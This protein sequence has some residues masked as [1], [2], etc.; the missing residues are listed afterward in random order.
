MIY[1]EGSPDWK[2][3]LELVEQ[4]RSLAVSM[5]VRARTEDLRIFLLRFA[6]R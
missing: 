1:C 6:Y 3:A 4:V 5:A 2:V